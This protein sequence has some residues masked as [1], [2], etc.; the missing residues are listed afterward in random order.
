MLVVW[1]TTLT[2]KSQL[3]Y[4]TKTVKTRGVKHCSHPV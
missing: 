2:T 3:K 4:G 1:V